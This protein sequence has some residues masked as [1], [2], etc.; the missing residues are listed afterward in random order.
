MSFSSRQNAGEIVLEAVVVAVAEQADAELL[1]LEQEAAE[2]E[3]ERLDADAD[4]VEV[5]AVRD[6]AEVVV[7][8]GFLDAEEVIE[9]VGAACSARRTARAARARR[10]N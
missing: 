5:V 8:E 10:R 3:L 4:A 9:A 6:V 7:D 1:V 2:I